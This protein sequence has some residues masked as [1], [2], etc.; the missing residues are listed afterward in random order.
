MKSDG[1]P[2]PIGLGKGTFFLIYGL[3]AR[4][5]HEDIAPPGLVYPTSFQSPDFG[6]CSSE[7]VEEPIK[8]AVMPAISHR[9]SGVNSLGT[10]KPFMGHGAYSSSEEP[11]RNHR[12][13]TLVS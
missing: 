2:H 5:A 8:E 12:F 11:I 1:F 9:Q 6:A 3:W 10:A 4:K 13:L 7:N